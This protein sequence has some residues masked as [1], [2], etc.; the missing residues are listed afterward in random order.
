MVALFLRSVVFADDVEVN[1]QLEPHPTYFHYRMNH[2][3]HFM[4]AEIDKINLLGK[5]H[6]E[7]LEEAKKKSMR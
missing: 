5:H 3:K 4:R 2:F 1:L 7:T 6:G